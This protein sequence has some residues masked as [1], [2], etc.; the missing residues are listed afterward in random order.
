MGFSVANSQPIGPNA[1]SWG[2]HAST[3]T[4]SFAIVLKY[5]D[6]PGEEYL[7]KYDV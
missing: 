6:K 3:G 4:I 5:I 1:A 2:L 7:Y